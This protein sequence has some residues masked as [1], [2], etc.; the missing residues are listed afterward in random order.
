M[1][2]ERVSPGKLTLRKKGQ[3]CILMAGSGIILLYGMVVA[4]ISL[5]ASGFTAVGVIV[6]LM[7]SVSYLIGGYS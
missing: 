7:A 5:Y 3:I 2:D 4:E 6:L 1:N